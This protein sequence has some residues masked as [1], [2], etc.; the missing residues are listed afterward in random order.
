VLAGCGER[1]GLDRRTAF[2]LA[3]GFGAGMGAGG[4]CGAVAGAFMVL[5]FVTGED[6]DE[7]RARF[8]TYDLVAEFT[9]RF[10]ARHGSLL[11]K[12]LLGGVDLGTEAGRQ[13]A[14]A[15]SLFREVCPAFVR[16]AEEIL[17]DMRQNGARGAAPH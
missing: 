6:A 13:E 14:Q 3:R 11:C 4:L 7:R 15:R 8:R 10:E 17:E 16:G 5:G 9:R 2:R 1:F 12:T